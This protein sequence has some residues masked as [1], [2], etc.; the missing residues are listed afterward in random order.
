MNNNDRDDA[1]DRPI[2]LNNESTPDAA[3]FSRA[4][5]APTSA[6]SVIVPDAHIP[7]SGKKQYT[8]PFSQVNTNKMSEKVT[9]NTTPSPK[10]LTTAPSNA[11]SQH[12]GLTVLYYPY[13]LRNCNFPTSSISTKRQMTIII[14]AHTHL[15]TMIFPLSFKCLLLI[16]SLDSLQLPI[17]IDKQQFP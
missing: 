12:A 17:F 10:A 14:L 3:V 8:K 15:H 6:A 16:P 13:S 2:P 11:P 7:P 5:L 9:I 4:A 1:T